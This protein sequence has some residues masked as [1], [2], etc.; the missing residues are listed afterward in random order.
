MNT[1][2]HNGELGAKFNVI[3]LTHLFHELLLPFLLSFLMLGKPVE[4]PGYN[5]PGRKLHVP[6]VKRKEQ[7]P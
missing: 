4:L 7:T 2:P 1:A 3:Y 6:V 5:C